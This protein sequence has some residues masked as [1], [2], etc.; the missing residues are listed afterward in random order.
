[1]LNEGVAKGDYFN[2]FPQENTSILHSAFCILHFGRQPDESEFDFFRAG[3][4]IT[5]GSIKEAVLWKNPCPE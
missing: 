2:H 4:I 1:M 5:E 3:A